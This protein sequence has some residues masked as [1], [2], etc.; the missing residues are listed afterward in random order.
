MEAGDNMKYDRTEIETAWRSL[1]QVY[2]YNLNRKGI[3]GIGF[4]D[5]VGEWFS[6]E[7][8]NW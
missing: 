3:E 5:I 4:T 8:S 1:V 2:K 7:F 6:G